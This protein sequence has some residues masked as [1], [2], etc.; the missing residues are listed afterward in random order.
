MCSLCKIRVSISSWMNLCICICSVLVFEE[1]TRLSNYEIIVPRAQW[2]APAKRESDQDCLGVSE[3]QIFPSFW[4]HLCLWAF[5][6]DTVSNLQL[7][8]LKLFWSLIGHLSLMPQSIFSNNVF[9]TSQTQPP[10]CLWKDAQYLFSKD[11]DE[12][13]H[14]ANASL[15]NSLRLEE[16]GSQFTVLF[17][18]FGICSWITGGLGVI[19]VHLGGT[20]AGSTIWDEAVSVIC[21][22]L[23]TRRLCGSI[24]IGVWYF[25]PW[26]WGDGGF[27]GALLV[28]DREVQDVFLRVILMLRRMNGDDDGDD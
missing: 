16:E 6:T 12:S 21:I 13:G 19:S 11:H 18:M 3:S 7:F 26:V 5:N 25:T 28:N 23:S 22:N 8:S 20:L 15:N 14:W 2:A 27:W 10:S 24:K 17:Q 1:E 4:G 9:L